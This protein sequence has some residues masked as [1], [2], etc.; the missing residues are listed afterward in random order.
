VCVCVCVCLCR[1][2][3]MWE[4]LKD[5]R[6]EV[7]NTVTRGEGVQRQG[8]G[9]EQR[10]EPSER[11]GDSAM[12]LSQPTLLTQLT[13]LTLLFFPGRPSHLRGSLPAAAAAYVHLTA[14]H[15]TATAPRQQRHRISHSTATAPHFSPPPSYIGTW[16]CHWS[17]FIFFNLEGG[18]GAL[19][20]FLFQVRMLSE[21]YAVLC[22]NP[23]FV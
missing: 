5:L 8:S 17:L 4:G 12:S 15:C 21:C 14:Y 7:R 9:R 10:M 13:L 1:C 18:L 6:Q 16:L 2:M 3:F 22:Y 19:M 23:Y 11:R 20:E